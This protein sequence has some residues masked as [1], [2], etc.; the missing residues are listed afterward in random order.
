LERPELPAGRTHDRARKNQPGGPGQSG[1]EISRRLIDEFA[2][3]VVPGEAFGAE[4]EPSIRLSY[5]NI[6]AADI[7][8]EAGRLA[9]ALARILAG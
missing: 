8:R 1:W 3:A 5:G 9:A 7:E 6:R 2:I 4:G